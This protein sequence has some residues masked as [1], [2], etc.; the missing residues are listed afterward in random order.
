MIRLKHVP[1]RIRTITGS[2]FN[3][4][5]KIDDFFLE[6]KNYI[7]SRFIKTLNVEI[8]SQEM[9]L[10]DNKLTQ[11]LKLSDNRLTYMVYDDCCVA[12]VFER[13]TEF[14]NIEYVFFRDLSRLE[15]RLKGYRNMA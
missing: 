6:T 9:N 12:G 14:N 8:I 11:E 13:R 4:Q 5:K 15:D 3:I 1:M 7:E 10:S 2:D